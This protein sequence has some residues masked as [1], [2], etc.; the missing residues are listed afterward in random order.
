MCSGCVD[1]QNHARESIFVD[2]HIS[3][4]SFRNPNVSM[5]NSPTVWKPSENVYAAAKEFPMLTRFTKM[6]KKLVTL[7][8]P[9]KARESK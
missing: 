2:E 4:H 7:L 5:I 8:Q 9:V 3:K 1:S 6:L